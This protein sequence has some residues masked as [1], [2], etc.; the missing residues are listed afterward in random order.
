[1]GSRK[2]QV[3]RRIL[4]PI[5]YINLKK[6]HKICRNNNCMLKLDKQCT[7]TWIQTLNICPVMSLSSV[8]CYAFF[9]FV[10]AIKKK[11]KMFTLFILIYYLT[12]VHK[13][14]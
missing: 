12:E 3:Q 7:P 1:M 4:H 14:N 2:L 13:R 9:C 8:S 6:K 10:E 11:K 5:S